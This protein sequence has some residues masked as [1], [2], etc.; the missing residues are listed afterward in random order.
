MSRHHS[1]FQLRYFFS[2]VTDM[3][4]IK[5]IRRLAVSA[6]MTLLC[7]GV[8]QA[9]DEPAPVRFGG[10]DNSGEI[11]AGYRFTDVHGYRPQFQQMVG[12][13][14]GFR[15]HD[16]SF[17]GQALEKTGSFAD[18]YSF[19]ANGI[20]GEPFSTAQFTA[21]KS[22]VYDLK[23]NWRQS[24]Y[25]SNQNDNVVLPITTVA[26]T[27]SRGLTNNHDWATVRK[28]GSAELTLHATRNLQ[29]T[30]DA[31]HTSNDGTV[32]TTRSLDFFNAPSYWASFARANPY[33]LYSPLQDTTDRVAGGVDYTYRSWNF[34]YK[35]GYQ[36]FDETMTLNGLIVNQVSIDPAALSLTEPLANL[37]WSQSRRLTTPSSEFSFVGQATSK[38]SWR[39]SYSYYRYRGPASMDEAENGIAPGSTAGSLV[40]YS[41]S[42]S[43]RA[44]V[45]EPSHVISQGFTYDLRPW[46]DIDV[47][48]RYSRFT[49]NSV[50]NNQSLFNTTTLSTGT[51]TSI[52]RDGLSELKV[53]MAFRPMEGLLV[54]PGIRLMKSDIESLDN[55]VVDPARTRR[56]KTAQPEF[57]FSYQPW[58]IFSVRGDW[59][60]ATSGSSYTAITPHTQTA[61]RV[62]I[63]YQPIAQLSVENSMKISDSR[64]V[65]ANFKTNVRSNSTTVTYAWNERFSVLGGLT[66]DSYFAAGN[67]VYARGTAPLKNLLRDQEINRI[68]QAGIE[69]KPTHRTGIQLA[70]N[71]DR[72]TGAGQISGEPPAYGPL[73]WPMVTGTA[74]YEFPKVGR[75]SVDLQRTYYREEL[76]TANNFSA[77]MLAVRWTK[78]I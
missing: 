73:K 42:E 4:N 14:P 18:R 77:N 22:S 24:Y 61:G 35:A 72:T 57:D 53:G 40:A 47:D 56:S 68:W 16:F 7:S 13:R 2:A 10:F 15:V 76:I 5:H 30:F 45:V 38:L 43:G 25:Y 31:G 19:I 21:S 3:K 8:L 12:L 23:V 41:I 32:F 59:N 64:L 71:Y 69:V 58:K 70:G 11:T 78:K 39:G 67:I 49:S 74:F 55:G 66:Y 34:H 29:F 65:D 26:T 33:F 46:W 37:A 50:S 36:T 60:H 9:Q 51:D 62:V 1:W 48:Y 44:K 75:L 17:Y 6:A 20:G 28:I 52:W 27:L 63:R 54:H